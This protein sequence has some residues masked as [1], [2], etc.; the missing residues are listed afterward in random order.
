MA[1]V[2]LFWTGECLVQEVISSYKD[3][4]VKWTY[5]IIACVSYNRNK[6]NELKMKVFFHRL[7]LLALIIKLK[8]LIIFFLKDIKHSI[9][10]YSKEKPNAAQSLHSL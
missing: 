6:K 8:N 2:I 3:N 1:R 9:V 5:Q 10:N 7:A 4:L